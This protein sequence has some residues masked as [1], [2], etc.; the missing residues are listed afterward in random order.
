[1]AQTAIA[2]AVKD[3][4]HRACPRLRRV[5]LQRVDLPQFARSLPIAMALEAAQRIGSSDSW[6]SG[7]FVGNWQDGLFFRQQI[8][9]FL[10]RLGVIVGRSLRVSE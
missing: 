4:T 1:M 7:W 10:R 2:I 6:R 3:T 8:L 5:D 9:R